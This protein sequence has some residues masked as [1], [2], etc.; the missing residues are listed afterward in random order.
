MS[1]ENKM[2][3]QLIHELAELRQQ[4]DELKKA[5]AER[6]RAEEALR[7]SKRK[8]ESLHGIACQADACETE[9]EIY[10][11]TVKAA[12]RI[13]DFSMCTLD[14]VEDDKLV[15]KATS[16]D[17]PP[18]A[19]RK[20]D[21]DEGLAG[22]TYRTGETTVF[23]SLDEVPEATPTRE[24]FKSGISVPIGDIGVFQVASTEANAFSK[25][26]AR[27]LELLLGHTTE[28]IKRIRLQNQLREQA[29]RD[30]L[31][32]VYNR[33]YFTQVIESE[34][35]RSKRYNHPIGFLII[36]VNRFKEINDRFGHQI[37][38]TVLQEIANLLQEQMREVDIVIRYGGDEFLT[39]LPETDGEIRAVKQRILEA[40]LHWNEMKALV[41]FPVTLS[42]GGAY[43]SPE[44]SE[45]VEEVLAKADSRMYEDKRREMGGGLSTET[46]S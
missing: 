20:R 17:L 22:K 10:R 26:D 39:V 15:V 32:G 9:D 24:D 36:D 2:Q 30:P 40:V 46:T 16:S 8:I 35:E 31:T 6:K 45:T 12:E 38:D 3:E 11:L 28:G 19:S 18:E 13:L 34:L 27:L 44:S 21:L 4:V 1:K 14:I 33:R 43:W 7:E 29:T 23:G 5:E 25:D 41:D 42:I 37:G